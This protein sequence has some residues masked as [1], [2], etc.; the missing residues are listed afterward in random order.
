MRDQ[1]DE[2]GYKKPSEGTLKEGE[3]IAGEKFDAQLDEL[4]FNRMLKLK[5][6]TSVPQGTAGK[7]Y[8]D[9]DNKKYKIWV[10]KVAQWCDIQFTSTSTSTTST[11]TTS[12]STTST[13]T[14]TT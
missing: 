7:I 5:N 6:L 3:F 8:W 9:A 10:D 12:T 14:S 1:Y 11:S 4:E 2:F 13:S